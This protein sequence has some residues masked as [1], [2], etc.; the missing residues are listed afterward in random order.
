MNQYFVNDPERAFSKTIPSE[1]QI[2]NGRWKVIFSI[3]NVNDLVELRVAGSTYLV[4]VRKGMIMRE[5]HTGE[6][7][8]KGDHIGEPSNYRINL[9]WP[10]LSETRVEGRHIG[11]S[12]E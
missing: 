11:D 9:E 7:Y 3:E 12:N 10:W 1:Y 8:I 4:K 2:G 6:K 5:I